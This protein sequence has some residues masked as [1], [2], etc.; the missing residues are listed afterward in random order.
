MDIEAAILKALSA[1][2]A[3]AIEDSHEW[4]AS[5]SLDPQAVVGALKSLLTDDYVATANVVKSSFEFTAEASQV[6][7]AGSPEFLV[8]QAVKEA[9]SVSMQDLEAKFGK[10]AAKNGMGNAMRVKWIKKDG[11]T[12]VPAADTVE[13]SVRQQLQTIQD[14][15]FAL[16]AIDDKVR[17]RKYQYAKE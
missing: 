7:A 16:D 15:D 13:D 10:A 12:I 5:Q 17:I 11:Q 2:A 8:Y 14:K 9:G 3:A 6:V 1:D 4:A